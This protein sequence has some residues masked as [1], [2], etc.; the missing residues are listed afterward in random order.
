MTMERRERESKQAEVPVLRATRQAS[1]KVR[2]KARQEQRKGGCSCPNG[3]GRA[4]RPPYLM[5][6]IS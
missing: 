1:G 2:T 6:R 5:R 3:P 4:F